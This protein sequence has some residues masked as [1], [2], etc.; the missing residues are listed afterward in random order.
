MSLVGVQFI[1]NRRFYGRRTTTASY[2]TTTITIEN[3]AH[4]LWTWTTTS[5]AA[6]ATVSEAPIAATILAY[7]QQPHLP[8]QHL[9]QQQQ[10]QQHT[11]VQCFLWLTFKVGRGSISLKYILTSC[12]QRCEP[13]PPRVAHM[14]TAHRKIY[15]KTSF[16]FFKLK[17]NDTLIFR[18]FVIFGF[19]SHWIDI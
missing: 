15:L 6:T 17:L 9:Q 8:Q 7:L 12:L 19:V 10:Q 11:H 16:F 13:P 14:S 2:S 1:G 18:L 4:V 5:S 3:R